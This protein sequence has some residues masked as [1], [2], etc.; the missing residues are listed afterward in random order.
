MPPDANAPGV[1][2]NLVNEHRGVLAEILA[3][4]RGEQFRHQFMRGHFVT[5]GNRANDSLVIRP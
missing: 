4:S 3:P 2:F 5:T 1:G